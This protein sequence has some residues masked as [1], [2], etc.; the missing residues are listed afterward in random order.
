MKRFPDDFVWGA[1][2]S[3]FQIEGAVREDGRG[4]SIWDRF[5]A[6]PGNILDASDGSVACDHYHRFLDDIP[7]LRWLGARSD[8]VPIDWPPNRRDAPGLPRVFGRPGAFLSGP[9]FYIAAG[10]VKEPYIRGRRAS[11]RPRRGA[12]G[13]GGAAGAR[14]SAA[15]AVVLVAARGARKGEGVDSGAAGWWPWLNWLHAPSPRPWPSP[16]FFSFSFHS[17]SG[18]SCLKYSAWIAAGSPPASA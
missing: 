12:A 3:A 2:T 18:Y 16:T 17:G 1:A 4:E 14:V 6:K 9:S 15:G 11:G 13:G 5:A 8:R 10:A 7:L